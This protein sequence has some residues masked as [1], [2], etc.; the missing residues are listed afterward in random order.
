MKE[1][2][3]FKLLRAVG[4]IGDD[5][6]EEAASANARRRRPKTIIALAATLAVLAALFL[7]TVAAAYDIGFYISRI[8]GGEVEMLND[9]TAKPGHVFKTSSNNEFRK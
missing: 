7:T 4:G 3:E 2:N 5:I 6:L 9:M 8:F 1:Q